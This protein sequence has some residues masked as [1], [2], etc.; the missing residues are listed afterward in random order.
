MET[1]NK[2]RNWK[3]IRNYAVAAS[4]YTIFVFAV[5]FRWGEEHLKAKQEKEIPTQKQ[6]IKNHEAKLDSIHNE[7][8]AA[9]ARRFKEN[10]GTK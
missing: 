3:Q 7:S 9:A 8:D 4:L 5:G 1:K 2:E 6:V 10:F